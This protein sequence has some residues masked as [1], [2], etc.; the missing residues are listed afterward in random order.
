MEG[1]RTASSRMP[2]ERTMSTPQISCVGA[3][4]RPSKVP[5][6]VVT[7]VGWAP[8]VSPKAG[9]EE[10][11]QLARKSHKNTVKYGTKDGTM[12]L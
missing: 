2:P 3:G 5:Q 1:L 11:Q 12:G 6:G 9:G 4:Q 7:C 8:E 10:C